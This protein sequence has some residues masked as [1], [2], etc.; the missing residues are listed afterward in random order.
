[1]SPAACAADSTLSRRLPSARA[2]VVGA[3]LCGLGVPF[4]SWCADAP[5][6]VAKAAPADVI[7]VRVTLNSENK[8]DLFVGRTADL[9][10]LVKLD[11]W[12][13][14]GLKEPPGKTVALDGEQHISL[15][16]IAGVSFKFDE[17]AL[18]LDIL[19]E[20]Q[21]L[22]SATYS[23]A[24]RRMRG[25]SAQGN[26]VYFN[27]ALNAAGGNPVPGT[28]FGFAG[29]AGWRSGNF[30]IQT[31]GA[32]VWTPDGRRKLVRLM[33]GV[34]HDD[35]ANL[36]QTVVGDFFTPSR[37]LGVG[38][39]MGGVSVSKVY[40]LDPYLIRYPMQAISGNLSFPSELEVYLNGQRVRTQQLRPGEF[41]L[42]D[43]VSLG[44]AQ[45]VQ[46]LLRDPFGRVQELNYS[47]YLSDQPLQPGLHEYSYNLGAIRRRYGA[48]SNTYGPVAF[49]VFHRYGVNRFATLGLRADGTATLRTIGPLLT[50]VL[51]NAGVVNAAVAHS[52]LSG[53]S[54][55]ATS[56]GY[57]YQVRNWN[58]GM[59]VRHDQRYYAALGDPPSMTNRKYELSVGM[60]YYLPQKGSLSLNHS[61]LSTRARM[62]A[63]FASD[64][65]PFSV[66]LLS[67]RRVTAVTYSTSFLAGRASF[68]STLSHTKDEARGSRNEVFIGL[69]YRFDREHFVSAGYRRDQHE[70][71]E[72]LRLMKS[73]PLGEGLGYSIGV[74][75]TA[76]AGVHRSMLDSS[77][78]YNAPA[79]VIRAEVNRWKSPQ[80]TLDDH[81]FSLAGSA[82]YVGG[83]AALGRPITGSYGIAKVGELADVEVFV[84]GQL[85]GKTNNRGTIFIPTLSP[86]LDNDVSIGAGS[87]PIEYSIPTL[88]KKVT[89]AARG[90]AFIDFSVTKMQ[91]FTG[92]LKSQQ[93][94]GTKSLGFKEF[95][96]SVLGK[97]LNLQT[98]QGGEFYLENLAPGN[99]GATVEVEGKPCLFDILIPKTD[100][101]FV[102]LGD[103]TCSPAL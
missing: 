56:L 7:V 47:F 18:S 67:P 37:D 96:F 5:P 93:S 28:R 30:L 10:F 51:G 11:D 76:G 46:L 60:S 50:V 36:R 54:G 83:Q 98:G 40:S 100:E 65:Q 14:M 62:T 25:E 13:A 15:R 27:Y 101:T 79:A 29:D 91:A 39:N 72:F 102:E 90:G 12:R 77:I 97:R 89:P 85:I 32:T 45:S 1:M 22:P 95:S 99:Y 69:T 87:V 44:G 21:L 80:Q 34:T 59:S 4:Q 20:P 61:A 49:S 73:Q 52:S 78:Q 23:L 41:E 35:V 74:D 70:T 58:L 9:D 57:S 19:V 75:R 8:G 6:I 94:A 33:S 53:R 103:V 82:S 71:N 64:S 55:T 17:Q 43:I 31:N 68:T 26:S 16:S 88:A 86:Y 24:S 66:T 63:S 48:A 84:D 92:K 81:R 3:L 38:I 42:R 2:T